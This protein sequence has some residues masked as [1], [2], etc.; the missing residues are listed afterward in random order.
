MYDKLENLRSLSRKLAASS[1]FGSRPSHF[2][3]EKEWNRSVGKQ[4]AILFA[5]QVS[6]VHVGPRSVAKDG[7]E[8]LAADYLQRCSAF[9]RC[10]GLAFRSQQAML[11]WLEKQRGRTP[12]IAVLCDSR[13]RQMS[14]EAFAEWLRSRRDGGAQHMV[15]AVGPPDG[16]SEAARQRADLLLCL[17]T[18]TL[19]HALARLVLAEQ[20]YRAF[21]ILAGHPYHCGH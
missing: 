8:A 17:G 15:F 19:P 16:W 10:S 1:L 2:A 14:S 5:M 3:G 6:L 7:F 13:G 12:A 11:D 21:T 20:V 4:Y 9:A 18:M